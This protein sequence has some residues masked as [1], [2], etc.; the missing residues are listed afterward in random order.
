MNDIPT[1][2]ACMNHTESLLVSLVHDLS[3]VAESIK[4]SFNYALN[5]DLQYFGSHG[6]VCRKYKKIIVKSLI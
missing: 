6:Y 2:S 5:L 3:A 1:D 4:Y